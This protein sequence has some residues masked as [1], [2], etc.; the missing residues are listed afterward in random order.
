MAGSDK[1]GDKWKRAANDKLAGGFMRTRGGD[2]GRAGAE[3]A[4]GPRPRLR[5]GGRPQTLERRDQAP[6]RPPHPAD[7]ALCGTHGLRVSQRTPP[8]AAAILLFASLPAGHVALSLS[9]SRGTAPTSGQTG[10]SRP[11]PADARLPPGGRL[12]AAPCRPARPGPRHSLPGRSHVSARR[13][14]RAPDAPGPGRARPQGL[15][16]GSRASLH[17]V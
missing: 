4:L 7:A 8:P 15:S 11:R 12:R 14:G 10:S 3:C 1:R 17:A 13:G 2:S 6:F 9:G 5:P 16:R